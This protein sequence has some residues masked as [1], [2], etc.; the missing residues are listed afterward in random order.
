MKTSDNSSVPLTHYIRKTFTRERL[1]K[2]LIFI[3]I[4]NFVWL[5]FRTGSK[6]SRITYPCQQ[7]A[8]N[9]L[10]ISLSA[11]APH[12]IITSVFTTLKASL[13][14]SKTIFLLILITAVVTGGLFLRS[15]TE[16]SPQ[17]VILSFESKQ[18][19]DFPASDIYI[20]NGR[21]AAHFPELISLMSS[22]DL[23][24]YQSDVEGA[25]QN[26]KG[27]I[28]QN[29]VIL[30]KFNSQWPARG[31]TNT[32]LLKEVIQAIIDHPEGFK[33]EI[34]VA[35]NG[36]GRGHLD[37]YYANAENHSQST[38]DVVDLFSSSYNVSTYDWQTIRDTSVNEYS[39]GDISDGYV[40]YDTPDPETQIYVS[41]P[42]FETEFGT[43]IS[44]KY[45]IWNG[46][47]YEKQLKVINMPVLKSH[48]IYGVTAATKNYMGVQTEILN[49]GLANGHESVAT[50]GMG[51]LMVEFGLPTLNI[52]DAIWVNANPYPSTLT[53]PYTGYSEATRVNI[54]LVGVD[55]I[56]LDYWAAKHILIETAKLTGFNDTQTLDPDNVQRWGLNEAYGVWLNLTK[57][58]IR[59]GGYNV[60]TNEDCMNIFVH[61]DYSL[62]SSSMSS[63]SSQIST[64]SS[65]TSKTS[66]PNQTTGFGIVALISSLIVFTALVFRRKRNSS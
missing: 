31:G 46:T 58:E 30:L 9:N 20:V 24:F 63:S 62:I 25:F 17:E 56:A 29:D 5:F 15:Q 12:T 39:E 54:L 19:T 21:K 27:L 36:Q 57:E 42:K 33:G 22:N 32:D 16:I 40:V 66:P 4:I 55:P 38:Q 18:A 3:G 48:E 23:F 28:N 60:T 37:W 26:P 34:I 47:G 2:N 43:H 52:I 44:F 35:D 1:R 50:G 11:I 45:G 61:E 7:A 13:A 53:G 59:R 14:K 65:T 41:Y 8:I 49:G 51:T 64:N 10:S 6:P